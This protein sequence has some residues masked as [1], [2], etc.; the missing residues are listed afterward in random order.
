MASHDVEFRLRLQLLIS[1]FETVLIS[2]PNPGY[3]HSG[4]VEEVL[5]A[6][7][8]DFRVR[9]AANAF[10]ARSEDE[11]R[12]LCRLLVLEDCAGSEEDRRE[13]EGAQGSFDDRLS[14]A[15]R[16]LLVHVQVEGAEAGS[17][18]T[19]LRLDQEEDYF[20]VRHRHES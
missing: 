9:R 3:T 18:R 2:P 7:G 15:L 4:M 16:E 8:A 10:T 13:L 20:I 5:L 12:A 1:T 17:E 14:Q 19:E 6:L 11:M